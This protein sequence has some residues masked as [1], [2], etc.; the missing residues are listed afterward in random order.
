MPAFSAGVPAFSAG[1]PAFSAGVPA[2]SAGMPAFTAGVPAFSK[3]ELKIIIIRV[4]FWTGKASAKGL[5]GQKQV[6]FSMTIGNVELMYARFPTLAHGNSKNEI[7]HKN[8][9]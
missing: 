1:V 9:G 8:R 2:F 5:F 3:S 6:P 4:K 7:R